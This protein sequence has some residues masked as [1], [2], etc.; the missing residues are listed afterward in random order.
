MSFAGDAPPDGCDRAD[1]PF[2]AGV[3]FGRK[4]QTA[5]P[6][7]ELWLAIG[8]HDPGGDDVDGR[9]TWNTEHLEPPPD[10]ER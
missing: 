2:G 4:R 5:N 8:L 10:H 1:L 9:V 3:G 7:M 6:D